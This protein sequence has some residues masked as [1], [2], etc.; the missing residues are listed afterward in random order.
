[1]IIDFPVERIRL[2]ENLKK[3]YRTFLLSNTNEI[4]LLSY[5]ALL[6]RLHGVELDSLFEKAYYSHLIGLRKPKPDIFE[7]VLKQQGLKA[8]ETLFIDDLEENIKAAQRVGLQ[9]YLL[10]APE[11]LIDLFNKE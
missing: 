4:H 6:K 11:T 3:H 1:M 5:S 7:Y 10:Q 8:K 2:L 9:T